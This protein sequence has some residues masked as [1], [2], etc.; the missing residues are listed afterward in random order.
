MLANLRHSA[1]KPV[2]VLLYSFLFG[3]L[4]DALAENLAAQESSVGKIRVA[5]LAKRQ[6]EIQ[7]TALD[8]E[9]FGIRPAEQEI[10]QPPLDSSELAKPIMDIQ[11]NVLETSER[12]PEDQSKRLQELNYAINYPG[13]FQSR[14]AMWCAPNIHYQPLYFEDVA[15]ERYGY[16]Y[17]DRRQ[18]FAS[19]VHF[20][21]SFSL[22]LPNIRHDAPAS[23]TYPLGF[24]RPGSPAPQIKNRWLR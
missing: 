19:A 1:V 4:M 18:P 8:S 14:I 13:T 6:Q 17:G 24:C 7:K 21:T 12:R 3:V 11:L 10:A 23:C 5:K 20:A 15:L 2:M 9:G 22:L 16:H